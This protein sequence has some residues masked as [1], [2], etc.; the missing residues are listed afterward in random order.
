MEWQWLCYG[1]RWD[2]A[3]LWSWRYCCAA[4]ELVRIA[5]D[6]MLKVVQN[7][8][9]SSVHLTIHMSH[10]HHV[11]EVHLSSLAVRASCWANR[12]ATG[13]RWDVYSTI[14]KV[15]YVQDHPDFDQPAPIRTDRACHIPELT[16]EPFRASAEPPA[17][18]RLRF[19]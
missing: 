4:K 14:H 18:Q 2:K 16:T 5:C 9:D 19:G 3:P 12:V 17:P 7:A 15:W 13:G 10:Q 8:P 6:V 1:C 11:T